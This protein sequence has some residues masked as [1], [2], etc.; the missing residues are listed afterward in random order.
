MTATLVVVANMIGTGAFTTTGLLVRDL[1]SAPAILIGWAL[2][3]AIALCGALSYGELG[4]SIT[5]NGGEYRFLS[6]LYHPAVGF[7]AGWISLVVGFSAPIAASALAFGT[8]VHAIWPG[9]PISAAGVGLIL[10]TSAVHALHVRAGSSLQNLFALGKVGLILVFIVGGLLQAESGSLAGASRP[11]GQ[12]L[13]SP[14]FAIGLIFIAF[15]YSGWNGAAY[16][17]GEVRRPER[18]VPLALGI[19]TALVALLYLGLNL[20]FLLSGP[21][22]VLAGKVE[23]GH[24]AAVRLFGQAAGSLLSGLIALALVSSV[25]AMIMVG[26]RVYEAMGEDYR[27]LR[28]LRTRPQHGGPAASIGLQA[29][30]AII[31]LLTASFGALL[32]YIG[33]TLSLS[34]ALTVGG[35]FVLRR[36]ESNVHPVVRTWG[37]PVTPILFI[38]FSAWMVIHAVHERPL[39]ALTGMLTIA[40]GFVVWAI[41]RHLHLQTSPK[42]GSSS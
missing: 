5:S 8:Y 16:V 34:A 33:F 17:A 21:A 23:I 25:S 22:A 42:G 2:G 18:N 12:A 3:G 29:A 15:A 24:V 39:E 10:I 19:G 13:L 31:M 36:R 30:L 11:L 32:T 37:Y 7:I 20:V 28:F 6:R 26:P 38:A 27:P 14:S 9:V 4:A 40:L 41:V 1:A 35:V